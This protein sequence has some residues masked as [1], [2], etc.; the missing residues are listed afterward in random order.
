MWSKDI[1][2]GILIKWPSQKHVN[3]RDIVSRDKP[4]ADKALNDK[5]FQ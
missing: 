1:V 3:F 2:F 4:S 5:Y